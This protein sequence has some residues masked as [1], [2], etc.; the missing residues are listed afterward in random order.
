MRTGCEMPMKPTPDVMA[1]VRTAL[2]AALGKTQQLKIDARLHAHTETIVC[3]PI[4]YSPAAEKSTPSSYD[5]AMFDGRMDIVPK[6]S[7][8]S[9]SLFIFFDTRFS[10]Q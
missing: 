8:R 6:T 7:Q 10:G 2:I 3:R 9:L 1:S 5:G 4:R